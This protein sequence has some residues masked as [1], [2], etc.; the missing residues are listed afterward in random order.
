MNDNTPSAF[1]SKIFVYSCQYTEYIRYY[2][3]GKLAALRFPLY[4][5]TNECARTKYH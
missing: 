2:G 4:S 3:G 1:L 5:I